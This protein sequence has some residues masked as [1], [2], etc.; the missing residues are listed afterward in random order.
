MEK[1][2]HIVIVT[3]PG[4]S[5]LFPILEFSKR[6]VHLYDD[7]HITCIIPTLGSAPDSSKTY[8]QTLPSNIH[9]IFLPPILKEELPE[10]ADIPAVQIQL[11]VTRSLPFLRNE[12]NRLTTRF[13]PV[14][15]VA[16]VFANEALDVAKEF[17]ISFYIFLPVSAMVLSLCFHSSNLDQLI[18]CPFSEF[19]EPIL[20]P[21]CVPFYGRDLPV[22]LQD[23]SGLAYRQYL[24]RSK[25]LL[26]AD[27]II[28]NSFQEIEKETI[29][30]LQEGGSGYPPVFPVGPIIQNGSS[31]KKNGSECLRWLDSQQPRSVLYVSFGSGGTLSEDQINELALGLE[32][33]GKRFLWVVRPPSG[34]SSAAYLGAANMD[35]LQFLPFDFLE[36]TREQ[37]LV[38][39]YWAPQI[40][41][42][43]HKSIGG[44]LCHC[45][46][47]SILE[48]IIHGV[49][50][51]AWP[52]FAEQKM[53]AVL[54]TDGL[55][56]GLR[57][58]VNNNGIVEREEIAKLIKCLMES[59][60]GR[61]TRKRMDELMFGAACALKEDGSS[62]KNLSR[63]AVKLRG[64]C[65]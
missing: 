26:L 65:R 14:A 42:L 30:A 61:D 39:C 56:V 58:K 32:L 43:S 49:P 51:I 33:S 38:V 28:V 16:D 20:I 46:W 6:L 23:R 64:R 8:L 12:L 47:N 17:D 60:E 2:T 21:G 35:P 63:L 19:P 40:E 1:A 29:R 27:G 36:R 57:P 41:V 7:F 62:M 5:H 54:L 59:E 55:K 15:L 11:T 37:G 50:I 53:N 4:F 18:S 48:G 10:I 45:G 24:E 13:Q 25:R 44:F 3:S 31:S 9:P 22:P 52:L 34:S